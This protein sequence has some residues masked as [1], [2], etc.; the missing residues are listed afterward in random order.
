MLFC[1]WLVEVWL[2]G[3]VQA[4]PNLCC[5]SQQWNLYLCLAFWKW[6]RARETSCRGSLCANFQTVGTRTEAQCGARDVW[7]W[8]ILRGQSQ[9]SFWLI[10]QFKARLAVFLCLVFRPKKCQ[11]VNIFSLGRSSQR[12]YWITWEHA[13][14]LTTLFYY[15]YNFK[16]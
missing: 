3:T 13:T 12:I 2:N 14:L 11:Q 10:E 9:I 7:M 8:I 6:L 15:P 4:Q 16:N 5:R 1:S